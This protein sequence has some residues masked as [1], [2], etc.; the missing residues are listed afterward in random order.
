MRGQFLRVFPYRFYSIIKLREKF[1][2]SVP[3]LHEFTT[4]GI[5][6]ACYILF[7]LFLCNSTFELKRIIYTSVI[8]IGNPNM[9]STLNTFKY[10][11]PL[12]LLVLSFLLGCGDEDDNVVIIQP[13]EPTIEEVIK[14]PVEEVDNKLTSTQR[15]QKLMEEVNQKRTE[16]Y[17]EAKE[18]DNYTT[19]SDS[20]EIIFQEVLGFE[21]NFANELI[22]TWENVLRV[23]LVVKRIDDA[24]MKRHENFKFAYFKKIHLQNG[25]PYFEYI[26]AYDAI[27][28]EY[29]RILFEF[30][31]TP[32]EKILNMFGDSLLKGNADIIYPE[33]F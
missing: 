28:A 23:A 32:A 4:T 17:E 16:A 33:G 1:A 31:G 13:T 20:S 14:E 25:K 11:V 22:G 12:L 15:A 10:I 5:C 3:V 29:L 6:F 9:K 18:E 26:G 30:P 19:L 27:I 8:N 2:K 24:T 21:E 7:Y